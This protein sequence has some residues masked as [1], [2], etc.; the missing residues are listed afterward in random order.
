MSDLDRLRNA[1]EE[2]VELRA[3]QRRAL[4]RARRAER[5]LAEAEKVLRDVL[6]R[7]NEDKCPDCDDLYGEIVFTYFEAREAPRKQI[8]EDLK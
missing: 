5:R 4:N 8:E 1:E 3:W 6:D 7:A 2:L